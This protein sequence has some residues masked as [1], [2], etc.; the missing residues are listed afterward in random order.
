LKNEHLRDQ[1]AVFF[2]AA[3][4]LVVAVTGRRRRRRFAVAGETA[5]F[6]FQQSAAQ[7]GAIFVNNWQQSASAGPQRPVAVFYIQS[8]TSAAGLDGK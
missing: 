5:V 3:G 7:Y 2:L 1:I 6:Q 4:F 8:M